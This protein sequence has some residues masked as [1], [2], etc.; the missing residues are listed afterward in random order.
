MKKKI[1]FYLVIFRHD[2]IKHALD[3]PRSFK[4]E[5]VY[6]PQGDFDALTSYNNEY[7]SK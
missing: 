5:Q 3:K 1:I 2:Y 6:V 7:T 4:P